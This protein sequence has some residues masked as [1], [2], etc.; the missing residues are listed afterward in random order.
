MASGPDDFYVSTIY[1]TEVRVNNQWVKVQNQRM[2][3]AVAITETADGPVAKC[4]LLR[5]LKVGEKVVVDVVG[6]RTIRKTESREQRN[7]QEFSFMSGSVSKRAPRRIGGGTSR[8]GIAPNS[9]SRWQSCSYGGAC[10][11]PHR[12]RRASAQSTRE[13][14]VQA[15]LGGNAIAVHDM[16][17][18]KYGN[19]FRG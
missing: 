6:I 5:D 17:Q 8:V 4:K 10:R 11:Y 3:G 14:Y 1:P 9:R 19:F 13:G 15:L 16:E 7:S 12:R 2:D 18:S